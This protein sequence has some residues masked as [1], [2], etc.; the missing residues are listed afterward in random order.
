MAC[1][2]GWHLRQKVVLQ[3]NKSKHCPAPVHSSTSG[4]GF[5]FQLPDIDRQSADG[6]QGKRG[7]GALNC[8]RTPPLLVLTRA[9]FWFSWRKSAEARGRRV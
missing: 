7:W 3:V 4:L 5:S 2:A 1:R 6:C 8:L 9:R